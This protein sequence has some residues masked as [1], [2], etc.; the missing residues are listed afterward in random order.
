MNPAE[1]IVK[2][3]LQE[4]GY[5]IQ[6]S[7][8][9]PNGQNREIDILAIHGENLEKKH[10][11]VSVSVRMQAIEHTAQTQAAKYAEKFE[12]VRIVDEV[13][14][15]FYSNQEYTKQ[16]VVGDVSFGGYDALEEFTAECASKY[17]IEVIPLSRILIEIVPI[18]GSHSQL[19]SVIKT[20]QLANKFLCGNSA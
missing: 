14:R 6:S 2:F 10:V 15:K 4:K 7:V 12:H 3:W 20:L 16:L 5:F 19:N 1:E 17:G 9:V 8:H 18:L 11:E 13:H